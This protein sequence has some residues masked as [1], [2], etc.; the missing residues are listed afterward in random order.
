MGH[1]LEGGKDW[2]WIPV[3]VLQDLSS[4]PLP[5]PVSSWSSSLVSFC[6]QLAPPWALAEDP[7]FTEDKTGHLEATLTT[8]GSTSLRKATSPG[9]GKLSL[10]TQVIPDTGLLGG[11]L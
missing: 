2:I 10:L 6:P 1:M 9:L 11:N 8:F 7:G 3:C 4:W 5:G